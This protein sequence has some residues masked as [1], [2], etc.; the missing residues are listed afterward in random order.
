MQYLYLLI[1]GSCKINFLYCCR[2]DSDP[3]IINTIFKKYG[4]GLRGSSSL[5]GSV[6]IFPQ[7]RLLSLIIILS[8]GP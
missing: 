3:E 6:N 2:F 4:E 8:F 7:S 5:K 1:C